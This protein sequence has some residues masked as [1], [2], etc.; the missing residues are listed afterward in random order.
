M[1]NSRRPGP[2][3][4][5][6]GGPEQ[7]FLTP[8]PLD[9]RENSPKH[10]FEQ[11]SVTFGYFGDSKRSQSLFL[12]STPSLLAKRFDF[13]QRSITLCYSVAILAQAILAQVSALPYRSAAVQPYRLLRVYTGAILLSAERRTGSRCRSC[14]QQTRRSCGQ[15]TWER[16]VLVVGA[17]SGTRGGLIARANG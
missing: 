16:A 14:G 1:L 5:L 7:H 12:T 3:R 8:L 13:E 2:R 11:H 15:Q 6:K 4:V 9:P 17:S 10:A